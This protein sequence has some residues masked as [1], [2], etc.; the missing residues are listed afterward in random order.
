MSS[1]VPT[2][3]LDGCRSAHRRLEALLDGLTDEQARQPT[4]LEG[5]T[6][7]H[8]L[9]HLAR[10]ADSHRGMV[11]AARQGQMIPQYPGGPAQREGDIEAGYGR[12]VRDLV[13]DVREANRR[14]E[15]AWEA[16][17]DE[18]WA[19]GLGIRKWGP[20]TIAY[21]VFLRWREVE[22]HLAD[23]L[24]P[25]SPDWDGLAPGYVDIEWEQMLAG[26]DERIP[27]QQTVVL[28]PG[29]RPSRAAGKGGERILVRAT[30]GRIL[31]WLFGRG[32]DPTW[33]VLGMWG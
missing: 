30:P 18:V 16:V 19:T 5:W 24:L 14:L 29:D 1:S 13:E 8:L 23:L 22:V 11:E 28:V 2:A 21:A 12:P 6:V 17:T 3:W 15:E 32:G 10:N 26:L 4:A 25:G 31:Q 20:A 27:S 9:T 33:P 7:G